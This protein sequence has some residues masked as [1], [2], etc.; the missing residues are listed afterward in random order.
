MMTLAATDSG[1]TGAPGAGK[2]TL[3]AILKESLGND[4]ISRRNRMV[5]PSRRR[6][7]TAGRYE[8]KGAIDTFDA[9]RRGP[10]CNACAG[11]TSLSYGLR[12]CAGGVDRV[13]GLRAAPTWH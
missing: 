4:A 1:L 9:R 8:R 3:A 7:A 2:S 13:R 12:P 6:A 5:P 10:C 11:R